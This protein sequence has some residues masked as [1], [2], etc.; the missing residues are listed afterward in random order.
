MLTSGA[1]VSPDC[2]LEGPHILLRPLNVEGDYQ[3]LYERSH[4]G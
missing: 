2:T 4:N 3:E 1:P